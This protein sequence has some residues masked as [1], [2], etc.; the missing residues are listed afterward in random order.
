MDDRCM[1]IRRFPAHE[2]TVRRL[3]NSDPEFRDAC[4]HYALAI[5][6]LERWAQDQTKAKQYR[7]LI[8]EM[9]NELREFLEPGTKNH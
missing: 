6:A 8:K 4:E 9:E 3:Y 7:G 2:L 5:H 1:V